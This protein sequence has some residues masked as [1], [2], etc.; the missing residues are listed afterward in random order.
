MDMDMCT[1][2][3]SLFKVYEKVCLKTIGRHSIDSYTTK[4]NSISLPFNLLSSNQAMNF[5]WITL[6]NTHPPFVIATR[7]GEALLSPTWFP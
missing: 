4:L 2:I 3:M 7:M 1:Y 5:R 6:P